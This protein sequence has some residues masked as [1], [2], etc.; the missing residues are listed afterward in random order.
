MTTTAMNGVDMVNILTANVN[1]INN[2]TNTNNSDDSNENIELEY[3]KRIPQFI[4]DYANGSLR[5][6]TTNNPHNYTSTSTTT[7]YETFDTEFSADMN[8][9]DYNTIDEFGESDYLVEDDDSSLMK[10]S[11][12]PSCLSAIFLHQPSK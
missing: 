2:N 5:K 3:E 6:P 11:H 1:N 4:Y 10:D 8:Y 7:T 12:N 9:A